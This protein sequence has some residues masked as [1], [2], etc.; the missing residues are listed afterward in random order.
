MPLARKRRVMRLSTTIPTY[1][2]GEQLV[3]ASTIER[4]SRRAE[5]IG[6]EGLWTLD[7]L[8]KPDLYNT[9]VLD[10]LSTLNHAA[11]ITDEVDLGTSILILPIRRTANVASQALTLQHLAGGD[12]TLGLGTG[13]VPEEFEV[14]GVPMH[15]RGPRLT[16]GIEVLQA[17]FN[18][19]A[20]FD[21]RFHSF[22]D[23]RID[24]VSDDPPDLLAGGDS[25]VDETGERSI[26]RPILDRVL[27]SGGWMAPPSKSEKVAAEWS[28]V[29][30][31]ARANGV[32]PKSLNRVMLN[33]VHLVD[34]PSRKDAHRE[35][36]AVFEDLFS[37]KRGFSHAV[38]H[39]LVGTTDDIV[40]QL[41]AYQRIGFDE[42][43]LGAAAHEPKALDRQLDLLSEQVLSLFG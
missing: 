10:P 3:P 9:S 16:E 31:Y 42:V 5:T 13:Y 22:E 4:W 8:V 7:H 1:C 18:G 26:P 21:G 29:D 15:E 12:V 43:I 14:T 25:K 41:E 39:C 11:A 17:L 23:V 35:Q 20:S 38:E 30:E 28:L 32:D 40:D 2:T 36:R 6:F 34:S 33:Y 37:Q 27:K 19:E 24:P